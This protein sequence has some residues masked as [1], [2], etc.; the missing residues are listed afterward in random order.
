LLENRHSSA[1]LEAKNAYDQTPFMLA[2]E[3]DNLEILKWLLGYIKANEL[4][5]PNQI[6]ELNKYGKNSIMIAAEFG[7]DKIVDWLVKE[8]A[9]VH[10]STIK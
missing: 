6:T 3:S 8:V 2:I 7:K 4:A 10:Y 9:K 5:V 1:R